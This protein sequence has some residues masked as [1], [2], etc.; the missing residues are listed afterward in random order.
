[1]TGDNPKSK[2]GTP[3]TAQTVSKAP[4]GYISLNSAMEKYDLSYNQVYWMIRKNYIGNVQV[5]NS[6]TRPVRV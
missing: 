6:S 3:K 5:K 2:A 4:N 1:M